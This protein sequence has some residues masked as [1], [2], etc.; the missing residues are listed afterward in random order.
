MSTLFMQVLHLSLIS[1]WLIGAIVLLR[2]VMKKAPRWIVCSL[3][4]LVA[5]RLLCP[6]SLE[7]TFSLVPKYASDQAIA[8]W[9]DDY[10]GEVNFFHDNTEEF[11]AAV[12]AGRDPIAAGEDSYYVATG[13]DGLEEPDTI[14]TTL[15][16][17]LSWIWLAG[18]V[19]LFIYAILSYLRLR[20]QV[21]TAVK[22]Q[23]SVWICDEVHSPFILGV[24]RPRIYL[25]SNLSEI[26]MGYV[27]AHEEAHLKRHDHWWKP[28][29]YLLF[30][31]YWFN[32]FIWIAYV[33]FC[34]DIELACDERVIRNM[35]L[36]NKKEYSRILLS[37]SIPHRAITICPLAFGEIGVKSRIKNV[38][39]YKKPTFWIVL[40]AV[41]A[42]VIVGV[43]FLT[44]PVAA[45]PTET[46]STESTETI[47]S[48]EET[49]QEI[50]P[51]TAETVEE[52]EKQFSNSYRL[53][54]EYQGNQG[55]INV[56]GDVI[57]PKAPLYRYQVKVEK[58]DVTA[59][60]MI[61]LL[62]DGEPRYEPGL[63][64]SHY[65][66]ETEEQYQSLE[67]DLNEFYIK[68]KT[69]PE[70]AEQFY[71]T[72]SEAEAV[73]ACLEFLKK[74]GIPVYEEYY[75]VNQN[76]C[77]FCNAPVYE[78]EFYGIC[79]GVRIS[80]SSY[81][82][83]DPV[84]DLL[85]GELI[86]MEYGPEGICRFVNIRHRSAERVGEEISKDMLLTPEE[87]CQAFVGQFDFAS[88]SC[89][90]DEIWLVY[91]AGTEEGDKKV[92][93]KYLP[94][95]ELH[96]SGDGNVH[97]VNALSGEVYW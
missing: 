60:E 75:K 81:G 40:L 38:L 70:N 94:F 34:R 35:D 1:I 18:M 96:C 14:M 37:C 78:F 28:L 55:Q 80:N 43:C 25:P 92:G 50:I 83:G 82:T 61:A 8:D 85:D 42:S 63:V 72:V 5:V 64:Y 95:W 76:M 91:M 29:A 44:D 33:L 13:E 66:Y 90:I 11:D 68:Y 49:I 15:V 74:I 30:I 12:A 45:A 2:L 52:E 27:I 41:I 93:R 62:M 88:L 20:R 21:R 51:E 31:L 4:A 9:A 89:E 32:P 56:H 97:L 22:L 48:E 7:S 36:E 79:D 86:R 65:I 17:V 69:I 77:E 46:E 58:P 59:D 39:N 19:V 71:D 53:D 54:Y 3:W 23:N 10:V 26:E 24:L 57:V 47:E 16:P 6:F 84:V 87:A 73:D 67:D